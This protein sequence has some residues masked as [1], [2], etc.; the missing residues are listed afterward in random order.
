M[1]TQAE[2]GMAHVKSELST[3]EVMVSMRGVGDTG[4]IERLNVSLGGLGGVVIT[5]EGYGIYSCS[6]STCASSS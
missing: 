1:A 2:R 3:W 4:S 6:G 5:G